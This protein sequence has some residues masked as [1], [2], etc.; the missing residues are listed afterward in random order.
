MIKLEEFRA[1]L[2][3][4]PFACADE[5]P[6]YCFRCWYLIHEESPVCFC[7]AP[8]YYICCY[9]LPDK[10][11]QVVPPCLTGEGAPRQDEPSPGPPTELP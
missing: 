11:T 7:E 5:L 10:L 8:F 2:F 9:S 1:G 4:V 3:S 6:E